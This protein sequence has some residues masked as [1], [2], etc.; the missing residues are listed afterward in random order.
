MNLHATFTEAVHMDLYVKFMEFVQQLGE[1]VEIEEDGP[2]WQI[3]ESCTT[4]RRRS[5]IQLLRWWQR[6]AQQQIT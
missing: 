6:S 1:G 5:G 4:T 2:S 3:Y